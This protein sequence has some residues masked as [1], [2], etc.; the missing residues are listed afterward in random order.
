MTIKGSVN[1]DGNNLKVVITDRE[2]KNKSNG[3]VYWER[4]Q[5]NLLGFKTRFL[6]KKQFTSKVL[7]ECGESK[8]LQIEKKE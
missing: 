7:D 8:I 2:F 6:G 3:V 4:R 1:F 5:W